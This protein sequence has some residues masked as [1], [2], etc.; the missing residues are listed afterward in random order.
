MEKAMIALNEMRA[1]TFVILNEKSTM[2]YEMCLKQGLTN[3]EAS[4]GA[5]DVANNAMVELADGI[6]AAADNKEGDALVEMALYANPRE[7]AAV[8]VLLSMGAKPEQL[9]VWLK[10]W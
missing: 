7:A 10:G 1:A 2:V 8:E 5:E 9:V 3:E 6:W 4:V